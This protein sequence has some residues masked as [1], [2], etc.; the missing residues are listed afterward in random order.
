MST[1]T[2]R[3]TF[4]ELHLPGGLAKSPIGP[5]EVEVYKTETARSFRWKATILPTRQ[6]FSGSFKN[7]DEAMSYAASKFARCTVKWKKWS[8]SA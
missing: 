1:E 3:A 7:S 2:Y 6:N 4:E 8:N 5:F